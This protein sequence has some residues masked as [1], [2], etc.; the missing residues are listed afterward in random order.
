VTSLPHRRTVLVGGFAVAGGLALPRPARAVT[1]EVKAGGDGH[2]IVRAAID[3]TEVE[4][5]IDTGA[6][7]VAIPGEDA[8]RIGLRPRASEFTVPV[9]TAN[10]VVN[11]ARAS[12]RR[13]EIGSVRVRDV[14]AL[15]M[16]EGVL[17]ITLIGMT[18][19]GRLKG[20]KVDGG[21]L[22]LDN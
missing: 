19:L 8:R 9:S 14:E 11:A 15:V 21:V 6:T 12:L 5:L 10:G 20:F 4:A 16:P 1:H 3:S 17:G 22:V 18:F 7:S 13:V 2:F